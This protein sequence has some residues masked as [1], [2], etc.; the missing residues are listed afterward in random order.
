MSIEKVQKMKNV[1]RAFRYFVMISLLCKSQLSTLSV[2]CNYCAVIP[3]R[4][5]FFSINSIFMLISLCSAC[6]VNMKPQ[7]CTFLSVLISP[8]PVCLY[9][10]VSYAFFSLKIYL[11]QVEREKLQR[12]LFYVN[13]HFYHLQNAHCVC[14]I[15]NDTVL[16]FAHGTC[17]AAAM[18]QKKNIGLMYGRVD[19]F[20][21]GGWKKLIW[22]WRF[23]E[24][25]KN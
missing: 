3:R 8:F 17:L 25:S 4:Q 21:F 9:W 23:Q 16:V 18:M 5:T 1:F 6:V 24:N 7:P 22:L 20:Y 11:P 10:R 15:R 19:E 2:K 14:R 12:A 13:Y